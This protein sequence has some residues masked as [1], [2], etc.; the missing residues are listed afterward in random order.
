MCY[1]LPVD[2]LFLQRMKGVPQMQQDRMPVITNVGNLKEI[3]HENGKNNDDGDGWSVQ[4]DD[5]Y[6][7]PIRLP[8]GILPVVSSFLIRR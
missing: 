1:G 5:G 4:A 2:Y 7:P 3:V 6:K 8:H